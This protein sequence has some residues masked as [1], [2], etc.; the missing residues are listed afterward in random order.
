MDDADPKGELL[1]KFEELDPFLAWVYVYDCDECK[2]AGAII[3]STT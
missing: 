3:L 2:G 1:L